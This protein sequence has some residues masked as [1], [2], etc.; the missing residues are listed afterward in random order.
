MAF[1]VHCEL[2]S[3]HSMI[4]VQEIKMLCEVF[5]P[6]C[7]LVNPEFNGLIG[8]LVIAAVVDR[9]EIVLP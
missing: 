6:S 9:D 3:A 5:F 7:E 4:I 2:L 8:W 1:L